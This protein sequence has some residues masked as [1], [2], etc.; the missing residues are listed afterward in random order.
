MK[1]LTTISTTG[2]RTYAIR[3]GNG[4]LIATASKILKRDN[5]HGCGMYRVCIFGG[6]A[7]GKIT[8][9]TDWEH[10]NEKSVDILKLKEAA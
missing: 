8:Y 2:L 7:H 1:A 4:E 10:L 6:P 5:D 3:D 9:A